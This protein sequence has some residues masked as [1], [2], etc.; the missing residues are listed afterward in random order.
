MYILV[1]IL[2]HSNHLDGIGHIRSI[3]H[4]PNSFAQISNEQI[5]Q[6]TAFLDA[7]WEGVMAVP[8]TH[9]IHCIKALGADEVRVADISSEIDECFRVC[10][11][12]RTVTPPAD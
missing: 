11:I 10:L 2:E 12:R 5:D 8:Q 9:K 6:Q 7:K 3:Q 4:S 1:F